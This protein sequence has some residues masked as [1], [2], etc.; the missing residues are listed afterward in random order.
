MFNNHAMDRDEPMIAI[1]LDQ[2][3]GIARN[4]KEMPMVLPARA[5]RAEGNG[6][7]S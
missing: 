5:R 4:L 2:P 7:G 1:L 6:N 3:Y